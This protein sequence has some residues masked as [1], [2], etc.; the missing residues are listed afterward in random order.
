[1]YKTDNNILLNYLNLMTGDEIVYNYVISLSDIDKLK[2][3]ILIN[4]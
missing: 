1:M 2:N 3:I 4:M